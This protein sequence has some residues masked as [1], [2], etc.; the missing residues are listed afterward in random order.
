VGALLASWTGL[1][2]PLGETT[3][4]FVRAI[5]L[6]FSSASS[7]SAA[8]TPHPAA[9]SCLGLGRHRLG[10]RLHIW[11]AALRGLTAIRAATVQLT[12]PVIAAG[13]GVLLLGES[14]TAR[15]TLSAALILGGVG[16]ALAGRARR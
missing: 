5:P 11:F 14:I 12:V 2:R 16:L 4:N 13:G 10:A 9:P 15:L 7:P 6:R 3:A 8:P 1:V